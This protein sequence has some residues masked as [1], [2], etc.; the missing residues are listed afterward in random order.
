LGYR[1]VPYK[2]T[3]YEPSDVVPPDSNVDMAQAAPAHNLGALTLGELGIPGLFLFAL[4][5]VRW[6]Q[7][8]ASFIS[9][10]LPDPMRRVPIGIFF[11]FCGMF[12]QC[13]T[14]WVF[15]HVPLYYVFHVLL[16]ALMSLY[17]IKRQAKIKPEPKVNA[18][19]LGPQPAHTGSSAITS[20]SA[21]PE[22][23]WPLILS[24]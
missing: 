9:K 2:G 1:F 12:L 4:V 7:M 20:P 15:R 22:T 5:W 23:V 13:L 16:G 6:F 24:T 10:K 21:Y 8:G 19:Q 11:G 17:F 18:P 3:D 14:E